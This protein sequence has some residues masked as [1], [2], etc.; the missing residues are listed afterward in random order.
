MPSTS[1]K[2][3]DGPGGGGRW[4][5]WDDSDDDDDDDDDCD[6]DCDGKRGL[7]ADGG[8]L[9]VTEDIWQGRAPT[10]DHHPIHLFLQRL[11]NISQYFGYT[12]D[13]SGSPTHI[14]SQ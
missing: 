6:D 8:I 10:V 13:W 7:Q 1:T 9:S 11:F 2:A 4:K 3:R 14:R 5:R 12:W